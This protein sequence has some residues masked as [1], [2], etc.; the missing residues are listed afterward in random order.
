MYVCIYIPAYIYTYS[1]ALHSCQVLTKMDKD[2]FTRSLFAKKKEGSIDENAFS[3]I[4]PQVRKKR[5]YSACAPLLLLA[6]SRPR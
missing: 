6:S 2:H 3:I 4:A 1:Y 5:V